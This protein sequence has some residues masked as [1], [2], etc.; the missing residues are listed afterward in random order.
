MNKK[1]LHLYE[2][3]KFEY[4]KGELSSSLN[5]LIELRRL[6]SREGMEN[7]KKIRKKTYE[8]AIKNTKKIKE[9]RDKNDKNL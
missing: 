5:T 7:A 8:E 3:G 1:I 4:I 2:K 6:I 9:L